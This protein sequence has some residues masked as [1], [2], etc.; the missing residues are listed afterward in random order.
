MKIIINNNDEKELGKEASKLTTNLINHSI[1]K[2]GC[3]NIILATGSSQF[4]TL[5][6][7]VKEDTINWEKVTIFHLD[8][9]KVYR[10]LIGQVLENI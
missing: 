3:A 7:L 9:Y 1:S 5:S 10:F 2:N 8:E 4:E 6:H